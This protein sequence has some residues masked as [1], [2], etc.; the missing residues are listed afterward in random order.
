M[1]KNYKRGA[2]ETM[3][4][5]QGRS[6]VFRRVTRNLLRGGFQN[7]R[8]SHTTFSVRRNDGIAAGYPIR[9][10]EKRKMRMVIPL[11]FKTHPRTVI[12]LGVTSVLLILIGVL[13]SF[14]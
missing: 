13:E 12:Y 3:A 9:R 11:W 1:R 7:G 2:Y 4:D 5:H 8:A 10:E 6:S 14:A